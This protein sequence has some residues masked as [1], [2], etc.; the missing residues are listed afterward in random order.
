MKKPYSVRTDPKYN[1]IFCDSQ[2][3][4]A[5]CLEYVLTNAPKND[6]KALYQTIDKFCLQEKNNWM[7]NI[8]PEKGVTIDNIIRERQAKSF[9]ELGTYMGYS[10]LRFSQLMHPEG[11]YVSI[12]V[13]PSTT[14]KAKCFAEHAGVKNID[15]LLGGLDG[16]LEMLKAKYPG[17]FDMIFLDHVKDLYISDLKKLEQAG[18]V[19]VGTRVIGDNLVFPGC[20]EYFEYM[21]GNGHYD[22]KYFESFVEY[23]E[24]KDTFGISDCVKAFK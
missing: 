15:F 23:T 18:L 10:A 12:D 11:R 8:G 1:F 20:P 13:N 14:E 17:G 2:A 24:F 4:E 6:P 9:L 7:M 19:R 3:T 16:N 22:T 21:K 5:K